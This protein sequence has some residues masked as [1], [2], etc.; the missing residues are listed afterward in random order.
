MKSPQRKIVIDI[1]LICADCEDPDTMPTDC[2]NDVT[3]TIQ[4]SFKGWSDFDHCKHYYYM[5]SLSLQCF[6]A[7]GWTAGRASGL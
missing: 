4:L 1:L 3:T 2:I 6:D 7:V 5:N